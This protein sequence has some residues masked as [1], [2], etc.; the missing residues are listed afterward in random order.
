[1][2][3]HVAPERRIF[4][5][6]LKA[7]D[8]LANRLFALVGAQIE[9]MLSLH[10]LE[11]IY[12]D[13]LDRGGTKGF[14]EKALEV[15]NVGY[16]M[17]A[18]EWERI[19]R[20]GPVIVVAN[21]PFGG[22]EGIV[23]ASLMRSVRPDVKLLSNYLLRRI[24]E[25]RELMIAVD[26]FGSETATRTNIRPMKEAI[27]WLRE[28]HMLGVF[29]SGEVSHLDMRARCITDPKWSDSIGRLAQITGA[30]VL[31]IFFE[32]M[33]SVFFQIMGLVHPRLRTVMLPREILNKANRTIK[34]K[35]GHV[36]PPE[37]LG[38]FSSG[39]ELTAYL[40]LRTYL[41]SNRAGAKPS[42]RMLWK[43]RP[44]PRI[45]A[46][47]SPAESPAAMAAEVAALPPE[48]TLVKSNELRV[49][50]GETPQIPCILREIGRL[51]ESTF[52]TV[53]EGTGLCTDLDAYDAYYSH[54]FIWNDTTHE[55]V[56][57][58]RLGRTDEILARMGAKGLY[59]RSLFVFKPSMLNQLNPALELGRSFVRVEY[60]KSYTPLLLLW[61]GLGHYIGL[62]PRYA[63]LF[64]PV[65]ISNDYLSFSRYLIAAFLSVNNFL[66]DL[67]RLVRAR[68][69]LR[70]RRFRGGLDP[71]LT[72]AMVT[73]LDDLAALLADI[74]S[75]EKGVP[76]LLKQY[77][78]LGGRM[79]GFNLDP[80]FGDCLD[81]LIMVDLRKTE[82]RMLA[83]Y[84]GKHDA[85]GLLNYHGLKLPPE[86]LPDGDRPA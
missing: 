37:K 44:R 79:L 36:I 63:I 34:I 58:Y 72:S 12:S 25:M 85:A 7:S 9:R 8:P 33:N 3:E 56:G 6:N 51:R 32:G 31:P 80:K 55:V 20:T 65:S 41:L 49:L 71:N 24:P 47:L 11:K 43:P 30:P 38:E 70:R 15:C 64:G 27:K 77:L 81:G 22:I 60:Q 14:P 21:H 5:L 45:E 84:L 76:I 78:R 18:T 26:P 52:R 2:R 13:I 62:H 54:L 69:P 86:L 35:V 59:T 50:I 29:P 4:K 83:R 61:K 42:R 66:P 82:P 67:S 1:M 40:R 73:D 75:D 23:L 46:P 28:G 16:D 57:A 53:G 19:P 48:Q 39:A 17:T 74:E 68:K 10:H